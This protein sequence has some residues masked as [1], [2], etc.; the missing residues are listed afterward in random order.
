M[1]FFSTREV[2]MID[3]VL[4]AAYRGI[5]SFVVSA[6]HS[7]LPTQER[8]LAMMQT[9]EMSGAVTVT[10]LFLSLLWGAGH[11][12]TPGHGKAIVAAYLV[13]ERSTPLHALYL[14][15][16]VTV[17]HTFGV[18]AL[19]LVAL[20]A[21][22]YILP[23]TLYPWLA[24]FSGCIVL[25]LGATMLFRRFAVL[26]RGEKHHHHSHSHDHHVR[27]DEP[28]TI[29]SLVL[30]GISGGLLPCPSAL[31]LLLAAISL[32]KIAFGMVL[33]VAFSVGLAGVLVAVGLLFVQG[34]SMIQ[35]MPGVAGRLKYL[36]VLSALLIMVLGLVITW[37]GIALLL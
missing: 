19:G 10:A 20:F 11:A 1:I 17:T 15:I 12:L 9:P 13:G 2:P 22:S 23:E 3:T 33:V 30:L 21:S 27:D 18:F 6:N 34:S 26:G 24:T 32:N 7:H 14:A 35:K 8:F 4:D 37:Q 25:G 29:R 31:A 36:P 16:T 5:H 28:V